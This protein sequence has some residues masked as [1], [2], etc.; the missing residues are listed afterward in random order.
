MLVDGDSDGESDVEKSVLLAPKD[1]TR[2]SSS[3]SVLSI[4]V[5][6]QPELP[7]KLRGAAIMISF[8]C[9]GYLDWI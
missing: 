2:R 9:V 3:D 8:R 4:A 1:D 7:P 6:G 5:P